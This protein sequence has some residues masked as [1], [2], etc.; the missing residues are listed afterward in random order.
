MAVLV[1][2]W[3]WVL[4]W[5]LV[6]GLVW[7]LVW[8]LVWVWVWVWVL[9]LVLVWVWVLVLVWVMT[10]THVWIGRKWLPERYGQPCQLLKASRGKYAF[11]FGDGKRVATVRGTFRRIAEASSNVGAMPEETK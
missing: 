7:G 8:V 11:L 10:P 9:V 6:W 1:W 5:V 4:V 3:V 2:V